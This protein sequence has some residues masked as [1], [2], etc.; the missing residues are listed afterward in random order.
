MLVTMKEILDRAKKDNYGVTAPNVQ[1]EDTVRAVIKVAEKCN[2]PMIIDVNAFIHPDLPWFIHMIRDLTE[3]SPVPF[4]INLDHG[5]SYEDIML[6]INSGFTSIM[7]DCSSLSYEDNIAQ[8]KETVKMCRP[9]N[10]SVEAEL[11]HVGQGVD[12]SSDGSDHFTNKSEFENLIDYGGFIEWTQ[13]VENY[14]GTPR[15]FVEETGI[16]CLAVAIGTA[17]GRYHGTPHIDFDLLKQITDI[18]DIPLVLHGGSGTGDENLRKAVKNGIQKVNL[19][20]EL[21]VAGKEELETFIQDKNFDKWQLIPSFIK[22]YSDR[23]EHY[24]KL[25]DQEN[26]AW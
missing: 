20:T 19:A 3:K 16:D 18:V 14:Y 12:Y 26:R 22:G 7:V 24:V 15:K 8:T 10:I 23:L 2:S 5:K 1:S 6:G 25:F 11:G 21:V 4:A 13:Y 9:L 17:H